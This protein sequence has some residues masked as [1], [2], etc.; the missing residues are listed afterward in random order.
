MSGTLQASVVKDSASATNNLALDSSG[1]V[2]VGNNLTV[3]GTGNSSF[4]GNVGIGT[5]SPTAATGYTVLQINN[6]TN[7]GLINLCQGGTISTQIYNT[8]ANFTI[9]SL[10]SGSN[11]TLNPYSNMIFQSAGAERARI[12]SS[13]N[14]CVGTTSAAGKLTSA[15]AGSSTAVTDYVFVGGSDTYKMLA[16]SEETSSNSFAITNRYTGGA[17]GNILFRTGAGGGSIYER[18]RIDGS[19]NLLVGTTTASYSGK[20]TSNCGAVNSAYSAIFSGGGGNSIGYRSDYTG[21]TGTAYAAY[22]T[23]NGVASGAITNT[24]GATTYATSSDYRLKENV[25]PL[26]TGLATIAA[27]K[28]VT[29]DWVAN[30]EKGEGFIAHELQAII[31]LAVIGEKDAVDEEGKI[32]PQGVDPGKIIPHLVAAL[33]EAVAKIDALETRIA[34]LESK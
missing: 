21:T 5:T 14:L 27:L 25:Q 12:D 33:Q 11:I 16:L 1:N 30:K 9:A 8:S 34:K 2:T 18:A 24:S 28:P 19:G 31:P 13:G 22:F 17:G 26:T 7:G 10:Q 4:G 15:F 20:I 29:Y 6:A 23:Y 3:S 32:K